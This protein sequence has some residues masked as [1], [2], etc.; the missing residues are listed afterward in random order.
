MTYLKK[1]TKKYGIK[2]DV[3]DLNKQLDDHR[4]EVE[5]AIESMQDF[6]EEEAEG[7]NQGVFEKGYTAQEVS[8][9]VKQ[10]YDLIH[11]L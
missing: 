2:A 5:V 9:I 6:L 10:A 3:D 4:L 11:G 1:I 7:L 8:D